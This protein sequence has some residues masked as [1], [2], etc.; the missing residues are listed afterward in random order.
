MCLEKRA[1]GRSKGAKSLLCRL[2]NK[3]L[4][5]LEATS[6]IYRS[7]NVM[8]PSVKAKCMCLNFDFI[9]DFPK[10]GQGFLL[11]SK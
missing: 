3:S 4:K 5:N 10:N 7:P 11:H 2:G 9:K 8:D 1:A 6:F